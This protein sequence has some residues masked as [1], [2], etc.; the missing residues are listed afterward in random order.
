[1]EKEVIR[2]SE[3]DAATTDMATPLKYVRAGAD[4][5][6]QNGARPVAILRSAESGAEEGQ[7]LSESISRAEQR[8]S[9]VTLDDEF[10]SDLEQIINEHRDPLSPPAWD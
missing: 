3:A 7:L 4:V 5:L 6:I 2:I 8:G 10:G 9:S 1:M